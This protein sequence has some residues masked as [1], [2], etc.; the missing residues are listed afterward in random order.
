MNI[1]SFKR[2]VDELIAEFTQVTCVVLLLYHT[3]WVAF[4]AS[5]VCMRLNHL[6]LLLSVSIYTGEIKKLRTLMV[7][8]KTNDIKVVPSLVKRMLD[9]N[10]LLFGAVDLMADSVT[11]TV[12]QLQQ[13][14]DARVKHA[15][16]KL[17]H[18]TPIDRYVHMD[19]GME[20]DL[21][22]LQKMSSEYAVAKNVAIAEASNILDVTDIKHLSEDKELIGDVVKKIADDWNDQ[23]ETFY[24]QT[25]CR[26]DEMYEQE[27]LQQ[28][29]KDNDDDEDN[30]KE[31]SQD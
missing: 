6:N 21:G 9:R 26:E 23:K 20:V 18:S 22:K 10:I 14:Q 16:E 12:N 15:Y 31:G 1:D 13:L 30:E 5:I 25:G 29:L 8:A 11:E 24:K 3:D 2:D 19:L 7:D 27:L 17:F 28:L 4:I